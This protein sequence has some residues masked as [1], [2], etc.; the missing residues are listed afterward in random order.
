MH[1]KKALQKRNDDGEEL[2]RNDGGRDQQRKRSDGGRD[3]RRGAGRDP[4]ELTSDDGGRDQQQKRSAEEISSDGRKRSGTDPERGRL[5]RRSPAGLRAV[6]SAEEISAARHWPEGSEEISRSARRLVPEEGGSGRGVAAGR[7][8]C[9]L[10]TDRPEAA[11]RVARLPGVK[12]SN[13]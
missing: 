9:N 10:A 2:T 12:M 4:E 6:L 8:A 3:Q 5:V 7:S 11:G 1:R 13:F